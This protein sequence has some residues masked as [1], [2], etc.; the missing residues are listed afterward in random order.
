MSYYN[1]SYDENSYS[2]RSAE[3]IVPILLE[4]FNP[5]SVLDVGCGNGSWLRTFKENGINDCLGIDG[6]H[7]KKE[8]LEIPFENF[9]A[10]NLENDFELNRRFDLCICLEVAEH[11]NNNISEGLMRNLIM[12]SDNI[13]FSAAIPHQGGVM[14]INEK[15]PQFWQNLFN[16][17]GYHTYDI[18]RKKIWNDPNINWWYKQNLFVATK[19]KLN[20]L[21]SENI[22]F[23]IHPALF[24]QTVK[25]LEMIKYAKITEL[26]KFIA[27]SFINT[28]SG[29]EA[30]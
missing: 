15:E 18:I 30:K 3:Q 13:I 16:K 5:S 21:P 7:I 25:Q 6:V 11:L 22:D 20:G 4:I 2:S 29:K 27:R 23:I 9:R 24:F 8:T 1:F 28:F 10:I 12:H 14:H 26:P 17:N 19:K